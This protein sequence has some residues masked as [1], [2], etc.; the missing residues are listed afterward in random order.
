MSAESV[1]IPSADTP[2][3]S[4]WAVFTVEEHG[5]SQDQELTVRPHEVIAVVS[6]CEDSVHC[7]LLL[8]HGYNY[9]VRATAD[10]A[11]ETLEDAEDSNAVMHAMGSSTP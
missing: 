6:E 5:G 7:L 2:N 8:S 4:G 9:R 1:G 10:E 11:R 3:V